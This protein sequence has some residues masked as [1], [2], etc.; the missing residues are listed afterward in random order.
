MTS[1]MRL[2]MNIFVCCISMSN[3]YAAMGFSMYRPEPF[4]PCLSLEVGSHPQG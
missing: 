2:L 1:D 3:N 4:L